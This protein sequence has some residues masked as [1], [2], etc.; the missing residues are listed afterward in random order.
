M[1]VPAGDAPPLDTVDLRTGPPVSD[2]LLVLLALVGS[3]RGLVRDLDPETGEETDL[4]ADLVIAH[5]GR[6]FLTHTYRCWTPDAP[7]EREAGFWLPGPGPD[8][9]RLAAVTHDGRSI[10]LSGTAGDQTWDLAGG[11]ERRFYAVRGDE[12]FLAVESGGAPRVNGR[13]RRLPRG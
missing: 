12:L 5:D 13:L 3:W 10:D 2:D 4:A 9:V 1:S 6:P 7:R 11:V 8:D